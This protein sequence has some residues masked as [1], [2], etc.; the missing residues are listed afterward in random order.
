[1]HRKFTICHRYDDVFGVLDVMPQGLFDYELSDL[2][3]QRI[4][5]VCIF[6]A[7]NNS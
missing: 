7:C 1:M 3:L 5:L 4:E 6:K 2:P